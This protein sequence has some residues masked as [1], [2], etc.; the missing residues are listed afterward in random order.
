[1][2]ETKLDDGILIE[3]RGR[4]RFLNGLKSQLPYDEVAFEQDQFR[5]TAQGGLDD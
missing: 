2:E 4:Y 5:S 3:E 1:L